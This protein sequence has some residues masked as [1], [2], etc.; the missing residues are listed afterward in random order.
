VLDLA[1][2]RADK[3]NKLCDGPIAQIII[4][5]EEIDTDGDYSIN[6]FDG[7]AV[8]ASGLQNDINSVS[9][10][11]TTDGSYAKLGVVKDE[12]N[13]ISNSVLTNGIVTAEFKIT[14]PY[15][16]ATINVYDLSSRLLKSHPVNNNDNGS[17]KMNI[18]NAKPGMYLY[19]LVVDGAVLVNGVS[20]GS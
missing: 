3:I 17:V 13:I 7:S 14:K 2:S 10:N 1:L 6:I 11:V 16:K 12:L 15:K 4:F 8:L 19:S 5:I 20:G 18:E 9:Y